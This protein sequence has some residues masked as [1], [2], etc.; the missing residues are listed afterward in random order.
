[1]GKISVFQI[2]K[3]MAYYRSIQK[4]K[5]P[6]SYQ[7]GVVSSCFC[8]FSVTLQIKYP[9]LSSYTV[10]S[11]ASRSTS[12]T[13]SSE[14]SA[15]SSIVSFPVF[16]ILSAVFLFVSFSAS[17]FNLLAVVSIN[18]PLIISPTLSCTFLYFRAISLITSPESSKIVR[19][20]NAP[21]APCR[22]SSSSLSR[23]T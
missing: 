10:W 2:Q 23:I 4:K 19:L 18:G 13:L 15:I 11:S 3:S 9:I 21:I 7:I 20:S 14:Y 6:P 5:I 17:F 8:L 12:A 16:N 1:M 22:S